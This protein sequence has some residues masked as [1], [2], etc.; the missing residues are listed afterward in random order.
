MP[1]WRPWYEVLGVSPVAST[2]EIRDAYRSLVKTWHPDRFA[3]TP[4]RVS[5]A[6]ERLKAINAAYDQSRLREWAPAAAERDVDHNWPEW[7]EA[8]EPAR[9]R[10]LFVPNGVAVRAVALMLALLFLFFAVAQTLNAL[11]LVA[12]K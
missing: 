12:G 3:T 1:E 5:I 4:D 6:E 11:D 10:L 9:V 2:Q 7:Y 8:V